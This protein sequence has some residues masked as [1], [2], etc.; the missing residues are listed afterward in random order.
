MNNYNQLE[1]I[2]KK[3][4][5]ITNPTNLMEELYVLIVKYYININGS[6]NLSLLK[7]ESDNIKNTKFPDKRVRGIYF[8]ILYYGFFNEALTLE[9][10]GES[11]KPSLTR[12]R[13]RQIIYETLNELKAIKSS[14]NSQTQNEFQYNPYHKLN[15]LFLLSLNDNYFI[16]FKN[17]LKIDYFKGFNKNVKGL[18][19]IL[20]DCNIK[21]I[22]YRK[23]YYFYPPNIDKKTI[24]KEI[25]KMNKYIRREDTI[26]KM[27]LKSKTVTY[28]PN[29]VRDFLLQHSIDKNLN[30]NPLYETILKN[31]IDEK[32]YYTP[33]YEFA[34]TQSW[35]A[36][37]GKAQW[38]QIGIYIDR[39]IFDEVKLKVDYIKN[40]IYKNVSLMNFISQA[41]VWHYEKTKNLNITK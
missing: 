5:K 35:K 30:L 15:S 13:V 16:S 34:K 2:I 36:R 9:A 37:K 41:L 4:K 20:N 25:Q 7:V 17:L 29:E 10:I 39:E 12:E 1:K 27:S 22:S 23:N 14:D 32:P 8:L 19:S 18:I 11:V 21:Q 3:G 40:N 6:T 24:I 38:K 26:N 28:V 33:G 31:F